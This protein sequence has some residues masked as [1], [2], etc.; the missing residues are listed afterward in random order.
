M[1]NAEKHLSLL[2]LNV[3]DRVTKVEGIVTSISFDL[4][5][6]VQSLVHP[7]KDRDNKILDQ[8]WF[9]VSRLEV[10]STQPV[11]AQPN[12]DEGR[13]AEGKQ[14]PAEKPAPFKV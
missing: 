12:Y 7:G 2:G 4:Y 5:G 14:G 13:Q 6:C 11:M 8:L 3:R 1:T 9:D 10:L